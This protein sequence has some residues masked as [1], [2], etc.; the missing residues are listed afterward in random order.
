[1][2]IRRNLSNSLL[3]SEIFNRANK[4]FGTLIGLS[5]WRRFRLLMGF[6]L[7]PIGVL[8][9]VA[10]LSKPLPGT[11]ISIWLS[12]T[13]VA[14]RFRN[15]HLNMKE[16]VPTR[17]IVLP[18]LIRNIC[19]LRLA[20]VLM[21]VLLIAGEVRAQSALDGFDPG[22]NGGVLAIA[23][24]ADGKI[25]VGG[26]FTTL[27]GGG[28]GTT[29]RSYIG[30]LNPDGTIDTSFDPGAN[31]W[32]TALVVQADGKILVGGF[33]TTLGGGNTGTTTRNRIARLNPDGTLD[34]S[35]D[36][37]ANNPVQALAVQADGS[38]LVAGAFTTLGGGGTGATTRN[39]IGR[40][41]T[42]GTL[43]TT[44]NP[45]ANN[46]VQALA[47]Q[48]DGRILIGG[49][50]TT[51]GGGGTGTPIRNHIG[52]LNSDGALDASF[53]PAANQFV[54]TS[55]SASGRQD[56]RRRGFHHSRWRER[57]NNAKPHRPT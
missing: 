41:N 30:R 27:G 24:Q 46:P 13:G 15:Q 26:Y 12:L 50:F 37:G 38:I 35:F 20:P 32:V 10:V 56:S 5:F 9:A 21:L 7:C 57:C 43:D 17:R 48:A 53:D 8:L 40:L 4:S 28:T 49:D 29:A 2:K 19:E 1:M 44:F 6:V 22:A 36:P 42:S 14:I 52:R 18:H 16:S 51:L 23:V 39:F 11:G 45:G 54:S 25:L 3:R 31:N 34:T 55:G 47:V 33:F